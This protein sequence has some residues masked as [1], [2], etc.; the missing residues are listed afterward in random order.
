[1]RRMGGV[2]T[3]G[4]LREGWVTIDEGWVAKREVWVANETDGWLTR[5]MDG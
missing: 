1:M 2:E 3:N 4:W 5:L